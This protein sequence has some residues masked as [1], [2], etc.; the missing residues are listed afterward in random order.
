MTESI[1]KTKKKKTR[2]AILQAAVKLFQEKG[3]EKTSVEELAL[4]SGIGKG[5]IYG[6]FQ[7]KSDILKA[8]YED[9]LERMHRELTTDADQGISITQQMVRMYIG[10]FTLI[11][12]NFE[13]KRYFMQQPT[14][15]RDI[16][17]EKHLADGN[18]FSRQIRSLLERAQKRGELRKDIALHHL[19]GHFY[20]LYV[21]LIFTW[22][23]GRIKTEEAEITLET[24][25][26]QGL[27]G[28]QPRPEQC[29][30]RIPAIIR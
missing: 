18:N 21:L 8:L 12:Q 6:Y 3:F 26:R 10:E 9:K 29:G 2:Q 5:T 24:L 7:T 22:F 27:E 17:M 28:M 11:A 15:Y 30:Q 23:N 13:F 14:F 19:A 20:G 25:F 16:H 4:A 1:R